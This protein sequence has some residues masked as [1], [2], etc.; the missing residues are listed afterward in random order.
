MRP[1]SYL[2]LGL[3]TAGLAASCSLYEPDSVLDDTRVKIVLEDNAVKTRWADGDRVSAFAMDGTRPVSSYIFTASGRGKET[4]FFCPT[5][6]VETSDYRFLYPAD[7]SV[8]MAGDGIRATVP[9]CQEPVAGALAPD[10]FLSA[11]RSGG[12]DETVRLRPLVALVRFTLLGGAAET[13]TKVTLSG[14]APLAGSIV[15]YDA[16]TLQS[17]FYDT[18][19]AEANPS[20]YIQ[21]DGRFTSGGVYYAAAVPGASDM[22]VLVTLEDATGRQHTIPVEHVS[23]HAG[24]ITDLG[25]LYL[26]PS[27]VESGDLFPIMTATRGPKPIVL[28]FVPDGFV[29]GTGA[30]SREE[31]VK[32]CREGAAYIFNVE[33]FKSNRDRFTVYVAWKAA[34]EAGVGTT[35]GAELGVWYE[36]YLGLRAQ[37]RQDICD[38]AEG[39]CPEIREGITEPRDM[40]IFLL[41]NGRKNYGAVCEWSEPES[42]NEG[43]FIAV[44]DYTGAYQYGSLPVGVIPAQWGGNTSTGPLEARTDANGNTY[45]YT[46]SETDFRELGYMNYSGSSWGYLGSWKNTLLHEGGG[47]GIG[48][49]QDEYWFSTTAYTGSTVPG[50][51]MTPPRG[52]NLT[53]TPE[54]APWKALLEMREE[55]IAR[56][57]RY[58]RIGNYQGGYA[59]YF[60][61]V[62]RP[63]RAGSMNDLRP[64]FGTW[65]RALIYQRIMQMSGADPSF[66]VVADPADLRTFLDADL[67]VGG[68]Y[69]PLRDKTVR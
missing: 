38:F 7:G 41:V 31:Y 15:F 49:L 40:G 65:D 14:S 34:A 26:G 19:G 32:A 33:P 25:T 6:V 67:A 55:L 56:D 54:N 35:F 2:L 68:N 45:T 66:D 29:D 28:M 36:N 64:Y 63:E 10:L 51:T 17:A 60:S 22:T 30:N 1:R 46:L 3:L 61:G 58:G 43:R 57:P 4:E 20:N 44:L 47:H 9:V 48:R 62:W 16:E 18:P 21:M 23:L 69:D 24:D 27:L 53:T 42:R 59:K 39:I 50:Q 5:G 52:L 11:G 37:A 13:V 8:T 12:L